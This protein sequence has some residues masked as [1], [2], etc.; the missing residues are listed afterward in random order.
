MT[1]TELAIA[2]VIIAGLFALLY[3]AVQATR[4]PKGPYGEIYP[5]DPPVEA[6]RITQPS[7][8]S[9][10]APANWDSTSY[11]DSSEPMLSIVARGASNRRLQSTISI[12]RIEPP[13]TQ[14]LAT[15]TRA[16]FQQH[17]AYERVQVE[18]EDLFD[19]PARSSYDLCL[20]RDGEWWHINLL[21]A[22]NLE[23]APT[24]IMAYINTITFPAPIGNVNSRELKSEDSDIVEVLKRNGD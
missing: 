23:T 11:S 15:F 22:D 21:V 17:V 3:P 5:T 1:R 19:D 7:G 20:N 4:N 14:L 6:N 9:I 16:T 13:E 18:R 12:R 10:I 24:Q 2:L 8:L